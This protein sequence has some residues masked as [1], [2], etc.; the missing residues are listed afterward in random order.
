MKPLKALK[1]TIKNL[2][3]FQLHILLTQE[4]EVIVAR[5]LDFSVSSHGLDDKEAL[6]SL[7][8]SIKDYLNYAFDAKAFDN[9]IDPDE[10]IFW[11]VYRKLE[12][13]NEMMTFYKMADSFIKENIREIAYA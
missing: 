6:D 9:I 12:L 2:D 7:T 13:Q 1:G 5:C 4:D 3:N 8:D 11:E 10:E